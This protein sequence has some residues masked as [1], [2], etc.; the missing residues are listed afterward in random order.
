MPLEDAATPNL[1]FRLDIAIYDIRARRFAFGLEIDGSV[2][3]QGFVPAFS[4]RGRRD[5]LRRKGWTLYRLWSSNWLANPT[6]QWRQLLDLID[7]A[8]AS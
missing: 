6:E 4:N 2:Y 3:H 8:L 5:T 1:G 7:D